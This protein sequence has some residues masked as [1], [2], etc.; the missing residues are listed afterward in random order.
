MAGTQRVWLK[1][2]A[3]TLTPQTLSLNP[4]HL[5]LY[6]DSGKENANYHFGFRV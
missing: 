4:Q 3:V 6:R 2:E 1:V 5:R